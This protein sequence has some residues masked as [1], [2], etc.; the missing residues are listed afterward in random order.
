M[1]DI[2]KWESAEGVV[3][4]IDYDICIGA[5]ECAASCPVEV[6]ELVNG[7]A[8]APNIDDCVECCTCVESCPVDAIRHSSC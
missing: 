1:A 3:I 2:K 7:K 8:T 4:K 6:Y 5:G